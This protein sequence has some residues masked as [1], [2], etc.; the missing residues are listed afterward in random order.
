MSVQ[1]KVFENKSTQIVVCCK[2]RFK[3][4]VIRFCCK[5]TKKKHKKNN[6][7]KNKYKHG[8]IT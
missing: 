2:E 3:N 5:V 4:E 1:T 8:I 6:Y 7:K